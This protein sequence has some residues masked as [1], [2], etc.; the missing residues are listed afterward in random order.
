MIWHVHGRK[1]TGLLKY[2]ATALIVLTAPAWM[3]LAGIAVVAAF[4]AYSLIWVASALT[5][6][7]SN[8]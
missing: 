1:V 3:L 2:L 5:K 7:A 8:G 4:I 6:G